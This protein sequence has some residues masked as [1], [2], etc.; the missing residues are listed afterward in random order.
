VTLKPDL[1]VSKGIK[2]LPVVEI[3]DTHRTGNATSE[4]LAAFIS[5][6]HAS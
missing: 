4:E 5:T 2:A 3:G 1:L 6:F